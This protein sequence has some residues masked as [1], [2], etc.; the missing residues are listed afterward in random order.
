LNSVLFTIDLDPRSTLAFPV[1]AFCAAHPLATVQGDS[2]SSTT[3]LRR[4]LSE[5]ELDAAIAHFA[6]GDRESLHVVPLY[7][8]RY[9]VLASGDQLMP[10]THTMMWN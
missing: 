9:L 8:E 1:A 10:Q 6:P 4:K 3:E 7:E 5:F 2:R